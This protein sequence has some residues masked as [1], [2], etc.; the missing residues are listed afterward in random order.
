MASIFSDQ[1]K[2]TLLL[3]GIVLF[4]LYFGDLIGQ[5]FGDRIIT[6]FATFGLVLLLYCVARIIVRI[7]RR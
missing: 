7:L 1:R 2:E 3:F 5:W 4:S 6:V